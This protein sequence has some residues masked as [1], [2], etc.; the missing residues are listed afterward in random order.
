MPYT[1]GPGTRHPRNRNT[2][3]PTQVV[4]NP[5]AEVMFHRASEP[6]RHG[7]QADYLRI[8][9]DRFGAPGPDRSHG[10]PDTDEASVHNVDD[11]NLLENF[12]DADNEG[13]SG[14]HSLKS[15]CYSLLSMLATRASD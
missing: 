11:S 1:A 3:L 13:Y 14:R 5:R 15:V 6:E 4:A 12:V 10:Y 7:Q 8:P 9:Q 2:T